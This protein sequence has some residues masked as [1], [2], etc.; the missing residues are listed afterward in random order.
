M[1]NE[2]HLAALLQGVEAWNNW[3]LNNPSEK[4]NL[5]QADLSKADLRGANLT[6]AD[7][8]NADLSNADL[9]RTDLSNADLS[10]ADLK[11]TNLVRTDLLD[12]QL[13]GANLTGACI[14]DWHINNGTK[15]EG[16]A[17]DYIYLK[18]GG[19]ERRPHDQNQY[20]ESGEFA[21]LVEQLQETVDL[22]FTDGID[23]KAFFGSF[24]E[25]Q[26]KTA[27]EVSIRAIEKKSGGVFALVVE[28]PTPADKAEIERS[29]RE[30]YDRELAMLEAQYKDRLQEQID[31]HQK[32]NTDL[33]ELVRVL[34]EKPN[35]LLREAS[36]NE[37]DTRREIENRYKA[38]L[39]AKD[40]H[41]DFLKQELETL[42]KHNL[43][44]IGTL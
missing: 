3:R 7:L 18:A 35:N 29:L 19:Q 16:I 5:S 43:E 34:A 6:G 41:I 30:K 24:V 32:Q 31:K 4:P 17:C 23:W 13:T 33:M 27:G 14:E 22:I 9:G 12:A 28:V 38:Q 8:S 15:F 1:A 11:Q 42:R 2:K 25:L 37:S 26:G 10:N 20:F 40:E 36:K 21:K 44:L 39:L